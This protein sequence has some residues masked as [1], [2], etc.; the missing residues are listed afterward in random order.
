M[1]SFLDILAHFFDNTSAIAVKTAVYTFHELRDV[2]MRSFG[3][4][5]RYRGRLYQEA[6]VVRYSRSRFIHSLGNVWGDG[7]Q[8]L[9]L[10]HE[11]TVAMQTSMDS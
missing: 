7:F 9:T 4:I 3:G 2:K 8:G 6:V 10:G 5:D 11:G 1:V